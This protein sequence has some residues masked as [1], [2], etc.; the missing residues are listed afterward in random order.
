[1]QSKKGFVIVG[2]VLAAVLALAGVAYAALGAGG[3]E[4]VPVLSSSTGDDVSSTEADAVSSEVAQGAGAQEGED[5]S[6]TGAMVLPD[7]SVASLDGVSTQLS[8]V[9]GKPALVGFWATWCPPCNAEAPVIQKLYET[10][11]DRVNFMMIDSASDGRDN[12]DVVKSWLKDGNYSYPVYID[13]TGEAA[14]AAQIYY[15]PTM[16]VLN[17]EGTVLTAFSGALDE[18][19]GTQLLEQLLALE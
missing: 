2:F 13:E 16:F 8:S 11:G 7:F 6:S 10:Y 19:G 1:M 15:L 12:L 14:T 9:Y 18:D 17:K 3:F 4:N 5:V